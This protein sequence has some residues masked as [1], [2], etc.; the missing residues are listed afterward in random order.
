MLFPLADKNHIV[1]YHARAYRLQSTCAKNAPFPTTCLLKTSP[2]GT[3]SPV[4]GDSAR[5]PTILRSETLKKFFSGFE[6]ITRTKIP[7]QLKLDVYTVSPA[8]LS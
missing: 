2:D 7:D 6:K 1:S 5:N 4:G 3:A 8:M